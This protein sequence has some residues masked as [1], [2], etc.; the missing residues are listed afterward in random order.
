MRT[1]KVNM[2]NSNIT[3]R[4]TLIFKWCVVMRGFKDKHQK[5]TCSKNNELHA[6]NM[7]TILGSIIT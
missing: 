2:L 1:F 6:Q 5:D 7:L 3:T 4:Y